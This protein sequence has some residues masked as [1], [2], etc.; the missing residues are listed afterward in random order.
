MII[1]SPKRKRTCI[2][3]LMSA[4]H[5][6]WALRVVRHGRGGDIRKEVTWPGVCA[7]LDSRAWQML[8]L[9][10]LG[11]TESHV[12][13]CL[14]RNQRNGDAPEPLH[15]ATEERR[16]EE[17]REEERREDID[18]M[19]RLVL[20]YGLRT[21]AVLS[22][23]LQLMPAAKHV[24]QVLK[25]DAGAAE[26]ASR[27]PSATA[28]S[29]GSAAGGRRSWTDRAGRGNGRMD[30]GN[31]SSG[32]AGVK[33]RRW[34][35]VSAA[36]LS[37]AKVALLQRFVQML[38]DHLFVLVSHGEVLAPD[39][40]QDS[41]ASCAQT[42]AGTEVN[43]GK[44]GGRRSL[45]YSVP[46]VYIESLLS[47]MTLLH[48][49]RL[50]LFPQRSAKVSWERAARVVIECVADPSV[51]NPGIKDC[52]FGALAMLVSAAPQAVVS[53]ERH[54]QRLPLA[55]PPRAEMDRDGQD[56][57]TESG[58]RGADGPE[59]D[60]RFSKA[61]Q[62]S[63][64]QSSH[65]TNTGESADAELMSGSRGRPRLAAALLR[66]MEGSQWISATG[67]LVM[68]FGTDSFLRRLHF[69]ANSSPGVQERG[70][71]AQ[72]HD[73]A[74]RCGLATVSSAVSRQ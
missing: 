14:E 13:R 33:L 5:A 40:P 19:Q 52:L 46:E 23:V 8:D 43:V 36:Y 53:A 4:V 65:G 7:R 64:P 25:Q 50:P 63:P 41:G 26:G 74:F 15:A 18:M 68:A 62:N 20:L 61:R 22:S 17:R 51:I 6:R 29:A 55:P 47:I 57:G 67:V 30:G 2:L 27:H 44:V 35:H 28:A 54:L 48:Q 32:I 60:S 11:G 3:L 59:H 12:A 66:S 10:R 39:A 24:Q 9:Q 1:M 21:K 16:E 73:S 31:G 56:H 42:R 71:T 70:E 34:I 69:I 38:V 58:G 49:L 45:L 37:R 72:S